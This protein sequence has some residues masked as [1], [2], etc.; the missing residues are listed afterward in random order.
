MGDPAKFLRPGSASQNKSVA[1]R[2]EAS[3]PL[4]EWWQCV[5]EVGNPSEQER[6]ARCFVAGETI[7]IYNL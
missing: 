2:K 5:K 3:D 1:G 4:K 6:Q 7:M